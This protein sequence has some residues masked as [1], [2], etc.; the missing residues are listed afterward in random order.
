ML[1]YGAAKQRNDLTMEAL[2]ESVFVRL[3]P[4]PRKVGTCNCQLAASACT[5]RKIAVP[6]LHDRTFKYSL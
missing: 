2:L 6:F 1:D 4:D 3:R 5:S